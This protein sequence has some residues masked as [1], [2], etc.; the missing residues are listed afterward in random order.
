MSNPLALARAQ[1]KQ[2]KRGPVPG[3]PEG[4]TLK[5]KPTMWLVKG[6]N[7]DSLSQLAVM[8]VGGP[9]ITRI[10]VRLKSWTPPKGWAGAP[11][12]SGIKS[13]WLHGHGDGILLELVTV[14]KTDP[15]LLIGAAV[16]VLQPMVS[17][18]FGSMLTFGP[19]L[20]KSAASL[21]ADLNDV[22]TPTEQAHAHLRRCD[23]LVTSSQVSLDSID[24]VRTVVIDEDRPTWLVDGVEHEVFVNPLVHRPIG[25]RSVGPWPLGIG[26]VQGGAL[27]VEGSGVLIKADGDLSESDVVALRSLAGVQTLLE[28]PARWRAQLEACGLL[29]RA[30]EFPVD[31]MDWL[32]QSVH[33]RRHALRAYS[34]VAAL[35]AWPTV[36][37]VL[38]THRERFI[39]HAVAQLAR[40]AYPNLQIIVGLHGVEVDES[41]FAPIA[42]DLKVVRMSN[43]IPFGTALQQLSQHAEGQLITK[44]DDDDF[45]G[46]EHVWDLV[47]ARMYS[48]ATLVGK[49]LDW[50]HVES[51]N[52]TAFRPEYVAETYAPFIAGGTML[53]SRAD[54]DALGGWRP[55]AKSVDRALIERVQHTGGT[56]YRTHGLGYLYER[57]GEGHTATPNEDH[58]LTKT[59]RTYEGRIEHEV[60][61]TR[62]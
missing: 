62:A 9:E 44:M 49:A 55:V 39:D 10:D 32:V 46:P 58:F 34:P 42:H 30:S 6:D 7:I 12:L 38:A 26:S 60:F 41:R 14:E 5:I 25:R 43:D 33:T 4:I 40:L 3:L 51:A 18:G 22:V 37:V 15:A 27:V 48:G 61:G 21:V 19:G 17:S 45:Y 28:L 52:T 29:V 50:I 56:I 47:L 13:L 16:R 11:K 57:R 2:I 53:I 20:P 36:S 31:D 35:N 8:I 24:R 54:L 59:T 1:A 23:T